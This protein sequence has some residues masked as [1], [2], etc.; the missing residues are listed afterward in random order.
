MATGGDYACCLVGG[1]FDRLHTGHKL[2]L[3]MALT[4][5]EKVEIHV[6]SDEMA[7]HKSPLIQ[8]YETRVNAILDWLEEKSHRN[9]NLFKLNDSFGPAP[10]HK[11]ADSIVATP[12]TLGNCHE[13]NRL[14]EASGLARLSIL[15]VPHMLDYSG[16]IISSSRIRSGKI[17]PDGNPWLENSRR[18]SNM[19]M[20]S[21]LDSELKTPMGTLFSGPEEYPEV[22]MAEAIESI[23]RENSSIIAVGDVTVAT[24]LEMG[25]IPDIAII[26]GMT[27][28]VA[29]NESAKVN[30]VAFTNTLRA[31]NP[32]GHLTP[33]LI[34]AIEVALSNENP[35]VIDVDGE[36]DLAPII[37]HC[38]AP[39]GSSVIY[40]QPKVGVVVQISSIEV[41]TRCR[42]ILALFEVVD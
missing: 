3:S 24:L 30:I 28:R 8:D 32:A 18:I 14:R 6:I 42:D 23:D 39:I 40:G 38:L 21:S 11:S 17:D 16:R 4:R 9:A 10:N 19:R 20:A 12:E 22:A 5:A 26:D 2:L 1:T 33:S 36:E 29:L 34:Q 13:I 25:I 35:T 7:A 37:I 15:E 31:V 27:K 41:K